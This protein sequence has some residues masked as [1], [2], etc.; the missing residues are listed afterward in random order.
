MKQWD[1]CVV[2]QTIQSYAQKHSKT[3]I[4]RN[5][6]L[7]CRVLNFAWS[8]LSCQKNGFL[9]LHFIH[10]GVDQYTKARKRQIWAGSCSQ[11]LD[12]NVLRLSGR[13]FDVLA[14]LTLIL[15]IFR[16]QGQN[17]RQFSNIC[18]EISP[19]C[20]DMQNNGSKKAQGALDRQ[21]FNSQFYIKVRV[22]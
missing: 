9:T 10:L 20:H 19:I 2:M 21:I 11:V 8:R 22:Y 14:T 16:Q 5:E 13:G 12:E 7:L 15:S 17:R 4:E 18:I 6:F 1:L 3:D